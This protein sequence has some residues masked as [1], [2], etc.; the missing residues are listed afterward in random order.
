MLPLER[1]GVLG[2][3]YCFFMYCTLEMHLARKNTSVRQEIRKRRLVLAAKIRESR[4][5]LAIIQTL[6]VCRT[7]GVCNVIAAL[8]SRLAYR[9][10]PD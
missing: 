2:I 7:W 1:I 3:L 10:H 8:S 5:A 9:S 4:P 6:Q